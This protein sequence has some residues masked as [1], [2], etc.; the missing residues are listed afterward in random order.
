VSSNCEMWCLHSETHT[1]SKGAPAMSV[2]AQYMPTESQA[3][4]AERVLTEHSIQ[5]EVIDKEIEALV[6]DRDQQLQLIADETGPE[7]NRLRALVK[8]HQAA[9]AAIEEKEK[10]HIAVINREWEEKSGLLQTNRNRIQ[11]LS[12]VHHS[13]LAPVRK[14]PLELL[15]N[16]FG[17]FVREGGSPW[18]LGL[19]SVAWSKVV[20]STCPLWSTINAEIDLA[21]TRTAN[22]SHKRLE[23]HLRYTGTRA[24][25]DL[26]LSF[27][28]ESR[29][30]ITKQALKTCE[31][32]GGKDMLARW[33]SLTLIKSPSDRI[34]AQMT[35]LFAHP[36][37]N[38]HSLSIVSG[39]G[40]G[41]LSVLFKMIDTSAKAFRVLSVVQWILI[42]F[43]GYPNILRRVEVFQ[44]I[45]NAHIHP[46]GARPRP[47]LLESLS[48]MRALKEVD[49]PGNILSHCQT[50]DWARGVEKAT[51]SNL[52][53]GPTGLFA[54]QKNYLLN[55]GQLSLIHCYPSSFSPQPRVK[56]PNLRSLKVVGQP[57]V[58]SCFETPIL[59]E[60]LLISGVHI[61]IR[62]EGV[63]KGLWDNPFGAPKTRRLHLEA[64]V[65]PAETIELLKKM[66][67]LESLTLQ[68]RPTFS[69]SNDLLAALKEVEDVVQASG[70]P[71][72]KMVVC[73]RLHNLTIKVR[74][75]NVSNLSKWVA[76][77][78]AVRRS[79]GETFEG[80]AEHQP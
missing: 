41:F 51:F 29:R 36:L 27:I 73:P 45:T 33:R 69:I 16:I 53:I 24:L 18:T 59:D 6:V 38:L 17:H 71:Q 14:M 7:I 56:M 10:N 31:L 37:P 46:Y 4:D 12:N 43:R 52:N 72:R 62:E 35:P 76:E 42:D 3:A 19:V 79:L 26:R 23:T 58:T 44:C 61:S 47:G 80:V 13:L 75:N 22:L 48:L 50:P 20:F 77:V 34:Q 49:L 78:V 5:L 74:S 1:K 66:P 55:L 8:E 40:H 70:L 67:G 25:L 28:N 30:D 32:I 60:L 15:V 11:A 57:G 63:L 39:W 54:P 21:T 9:L 65:P 64:V 2:S 68:E